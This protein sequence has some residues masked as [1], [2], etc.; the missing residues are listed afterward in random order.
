MPLSTGSFPW[1]VTYLGGGVG[2]ADEWLRWTA[3][4][5]VVSWAPVRT[6]GAPGLH[7]LL[8]GK[9]PRPGQS[10]PKPWQWRILKPRLCELRHS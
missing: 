2:N 5:H 9:G 1:G 7:Q 6:A 4:G 8:P 10:P 3:E